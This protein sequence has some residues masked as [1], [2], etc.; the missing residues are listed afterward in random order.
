MEKVYLLPSKKKLFCM[1][2]TLLTLLAASFL[3]G[4][5]SNDKKKDAVKTD[6]KDEMTASATTDMTMVDT[7]AMNKNWQD[8]MA[9]T[10][11]HKMMESWAGTWT[12]EITSWE[13][14]GA[15]PQ[16]SPGSAEFKSVMN[17][18]F[19][20][21]VHTSTMMG[22]PF[23]GHSTM[24]YDNMK[25]KYISSWIDNMGSQIMTMEGTWDAATKSLTM[26]GKCYNPSFGKECGMREVFK[27]IDDNNQVMEMYGPGPG[28]EWKMIEIKS[29]RKK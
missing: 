19:L 24:G 23:E 18:M 27:P 16:T 6:P 10:E 9:K 13:K 2:K 22:M 8:N 5:C 15:A 29:T 11:M 26:T 3:L 21:G 4:A 7:A 20:E 17:G 25:K 12:S 14:P 1:K 28:G